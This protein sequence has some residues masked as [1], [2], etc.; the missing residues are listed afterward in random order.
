MK[1]VLVI[2]YYFPPMGGSG[3]QRPLKFVKYLRDFGWNPIVL[4]PEPGAYHAFDESLQEEL[5][6]L[7]IEVHRVKG[8]T[9]LHKSGNRTLKLPNKIE[10]FL[11]SVSQLF[12]LPD[13]KKGWIKPGFAKAKEIVKERNIDL[14]FASAP[15]YSNLMLAKM[16]KDEF[17]LP[18]VMDLRDE[19]LESHF[20]SY[21]SSF[22][23]SKMASLELETLRV[24]DQLITINS[25][26]ADSINSRKVNKKEVEV[27][28]HGF[29]HEDFEKMEEKPVNTNT[30]SFL[31]S[32]TFYPESGPEVFLEAIESLIL[33]N[34]SYQSLIELQFQGHMT[35]EQK[36]MLKK[37]SAKHKLTNYGFIPHQQAV[38]N[39]MNA[40][41]LWLNNAHKKNPEIISLGKTYEYMATR[42][43]IIAL[44]PEGEVKE[45]LKEYGASLISEPTDVN[46][47]KEHINTLIKL[48]E[49]DDLPNPSHDFVNRFSRKELT[50]KLAETFN[51][52]TS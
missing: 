44:V 20:I 29:D 15:P 17:D 40:D 35:N 1:N 32:G 48:W 5:D 51:V 31:Y 23:R 47:L 14:V 45:T 43:P 13:N 7:N 19:W 10:R 38:E 37:F 6:S 18:V 25:N 3:V 2:V 8:G 33:E 41:I 24:A 9:L 49:K 11:R 21:P 36:A 4:C 16:I 28:P 42:K 39:L 50:K 26:I 52:I 30:I 12:W 27:I 22:H 34:P 46:A